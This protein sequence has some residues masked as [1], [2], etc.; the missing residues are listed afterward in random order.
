M[1]KSNYLCTGI[2]QEYLMNGHFSL[3]LF[4][5]KSNTNCIFAVWFLQKGSECLK[6]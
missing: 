3:T 1:Y 5:K 4:F 2:H 6:C